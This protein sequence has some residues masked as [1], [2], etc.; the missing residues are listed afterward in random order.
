[1]IK[2]SAYLEE[3]KRQLI[4]EEKNDF[5]T[6][7]KIYEAMWNEAVALG[8]LPLKNP[9]EGIED[10]LRISRIMNRLPE[11]NYPPELLEYLN[12]EVLNGKKDIK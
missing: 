5:A 3:F 9:Y 7:L 11:D 10:A 6:N 4:R 2:N 8:V 12:K 1:M